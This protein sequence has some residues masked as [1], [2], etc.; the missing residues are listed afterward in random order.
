MVI[1]KGRVPIAGGNMNFDVADNL[2]DVAM[3]YCS[4]NY[5]HEIAQAKSVS[6]ET[7][8]SLTVES[9]LYEY[10]WAVYASGF[11][12]DTVE[13]KMPFLTEIFFHFDV[14]RIV[15]AGSVD[16]AL[17][18]INNRRKLKSFLDG[19]KAICD[20]GFDK[21][22]L[23]L[24]AKGVDGLEDLP[25]IGPITKFHLGKNIGLIDAAKPDIWLE[26]AA[27]RCTCSVDELV[28]YLSGKY[29]ISKNTVDVVLWR[30][31]ADRKL[32][33]I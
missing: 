7:F 27:A 22:K 14:E 29:R 28:T 26:R 5:P 19:C 21:F 24:R 25:G 33:M 15:S 9:F 1:G 23:T 16:S 18:V 30:Y 2:F 13:A 11:K 32:E 12:S 20:I 4:E 31:G 17:D 3:A 8:E 10:C 6:S